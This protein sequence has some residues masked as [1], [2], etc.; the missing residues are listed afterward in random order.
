MRSMQALFFV[1]LCIACVCMKKVLYTLVSV[2]I[3]LF[4]CFSSARSAFTT[5]PWYNVAEKGKHHTSHKWFRIVQN[6]NFFL[7]NSFLLQHSLLRDAY[8]K[9]QK[10][11][12]NKTLISSFLFMQY[13]KINEQEKQDSMLSLKVQKLKRKKKAQKS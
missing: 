6:Y 10:Y 1:L 5:T 3:S 4:D 9:I 8:N 12:T 2:F 13:F 11:S 7:Y